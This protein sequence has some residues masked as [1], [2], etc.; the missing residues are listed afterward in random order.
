MIRG[1]F[2]NCST[3]S[4]ERSKNSSALL[5]HMF[6][7]QNRHQSHLSKSVTTARAHSNEHFNELHVSFRLFLLFT[8][9]AI[10][11]PITFQRGGMMSQCEW[12][13]WRQIPEE[14]QERSQ[15]FMEVT[16]ASRRPKIPS[17]TFRRLM[18]K[19][20]MERSCKSPLVRQKDGLSFCNTGPLGV[21]GCHTKSTIHRKIETQKKWEGGGSLA[22]WDCSRRLLLI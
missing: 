13:R 17:P 16:G 1:N 2:P 6:W 4:S 19:E 8:S 14:Q 15:L 3:K 5:T 18:R 7:N 12:S 10:T 9:A 22:S 11:F 21:F 20:R